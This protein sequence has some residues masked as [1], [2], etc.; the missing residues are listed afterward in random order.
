MK[1]QFKGAPPRLEAPIQI[2]DGPSG[3]KYSENL[4]RND[5]MLPHL[6]KEQQAILSFQEKN[7]AHN[8]C[9]L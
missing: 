4:L 7:N 1:M 3:N 8:H 6:F 5:N 2:T 9:H